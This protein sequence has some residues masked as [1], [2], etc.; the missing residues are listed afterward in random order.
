MA[1]GL[2]AWAP[3]A[4]VDGRWQF[5]VVLT[6][7]SRGYWSSVTPGYG[8]APEQA[9]RLAG[10]VL[11]GLVD[12][13]GHAFQRAFTGL[14]EQRFELRDDFWAWRDRMYQVAQRLSPALLKAVA[15]QCF[16]ELLSGGYTH[17]CE[18]HYLRGASGFESDV[19]DWRMDEALIEAADETGI[20]LTICPVLY[21]R[22]GFKSFGLKP[23]QQSFRLDATGVWRVAQRIQSL[24]HERVSA[25][26]AIHSLR[27]ASAESIAQLLRLAAEVDW[28]IHIHVA[29]QTQEVD[30]CL[31]ATGMRP[32]QWL[33][34]MNLLDSRWH[35]VHATHTNPEEIDAVAAADSSVVICPST[36]ANLGDG[37]T[38]VPRWLKAGVPISIGSDSEIGRDWRDEFRWLELGQRL[39]RR[40]RGVCAEPT[41]WTSP[42][43]RLFE[44][45]LSAGSAAAGLSGSG[46]RVGARAD[47]LVADPLDSALLG[48][49]PERMLDALVFSSPVKPWRDV[50]V[51]GRW[52]ILDGHHPFASRAAEQFVS[53]MKV[54]WEESIT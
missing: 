11:P 22:S 12:A 2:I 20:G 53:A 27:A 6:V 21:E 52:G 23:Q 38:D 48:L 32:V 54:I 36:E 8:Q 4:W 3:Q 9:T 16:V 42:A 28:P 45:G 1:A 13:H 18:F 41:T 17:R 43:E 46:L 31:A 30:D 50:M 35:L 44:D 10:P 34:R 25:G 39:V 37:L 29:E 15:A 19:D 40:E 7:N 33:A 24:A 47:L 14:T 26:L 51:A 49:P 5:G